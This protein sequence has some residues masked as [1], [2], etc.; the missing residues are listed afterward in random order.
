MK[1]F[2]PYKV[3]SYGIGMGASTR[4]EWFPHVKYISA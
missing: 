2:L 1:V 4:D 3:Q